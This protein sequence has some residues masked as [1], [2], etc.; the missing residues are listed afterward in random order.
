M[1]RQI[2]SAALF[3]L[4][5]VTGAAA[6]AS[7]AQ[8]EP[9]R[10]AVTT[11]GSD[12][13]GLCG[14]DCMEVISAKGEID[15]ETADAFAAFLANHQQEQNLRP[16]VLIDS[17]GGTVVGA[18]RLGTQFRSFGA[19]LIVGEALRERGSDRMRLAPAVC[20]SACVY[21]FFGGRDRVVPSTSRLGIHRMVIKEDMRDPSGA[22]AEQQ[23]FG[24]PEIVQ[25][26]SDY[27]RSMGIN[28][29][30]ILQAE[31]IAP[32]TIR[33]L[34]QKEIARWRLARSRF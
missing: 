21:A 5:A 23:T 20:L 3:A 13:G 6:F 34:T 26:L 24:T 22:Y 27:T 2:G 16:V 29:D 33:I 31:R 8:A 25:T 14:P 11:L 30:V 19:E 1:A 15:N 4:F 32:E 10:F 18:M 9:M 7:A 17:F 12:A 28:P